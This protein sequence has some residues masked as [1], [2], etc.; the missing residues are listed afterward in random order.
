LDG[1]F[2][3]CVEFA[4]PALHTIDTD[5]QPGDLDFG[6]LLQQWHCLTNR[7]ARRRHVFYDQNLLTVA[8][9]VTNQV[10]ALSVIFRLFAVEAERYVEAALGED[11]RDA[12]DQRDALVGGAEQEV[13]LY[14]LF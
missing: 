11:H 7:S 12:H 8:R 10:T 6:R 1:E 4:R 2:I 14:A 9:N 3:E 13:E 5:D